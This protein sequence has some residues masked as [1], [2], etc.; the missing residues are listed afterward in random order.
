LDH[1]HICALYD[2]G[3]QN[4]TA[5]LVMQYL[6]GETLEKRLKGGAL[7]L[8]HALQCAIQIAD[9]LDKAHRAGIIHRDLKP[10]NIFL[11]KAGAKL[12]DFGLAKARSPR[13]IVHP[14]DDTDESHRPGND[15]RDVPIHGART[16]RRA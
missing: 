4:G 7:P 16:A 8:D 6:E 14:P 1:P 5:F 15:P 11:T 3:E 12:L 2:V 13:G 10:G 9:A